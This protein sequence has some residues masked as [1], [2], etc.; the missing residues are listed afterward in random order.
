MSI[1]SKLAGKIANSVSQDSVKADFKEPSTPEMSALCREAGAEGIVMLKNKDNVLPLKKEN[2]VSVF[3]RVQ[4]DYFYVGYGSG[5]DVNAPY[6][7][8]LI[9]GMEN[10][11]DI[12]LNG[13]L[14]DI[15]KT[16]CENNPVDDGWWGHWPMCYEEMPVSTDL[17]DEMSKISDIAVVVI[18]R[19][20]GE[21]RENTLTEGSWYLTR[22]ERTMLDS[23]T[24]AFSKVVVLLDCGSIMDMSWVEEYGDSI[25]AVLYVWQG[26]MESGNSIADVLCGKVSPS[27][28]LTDTIAKKYEYYPSSKDFGNKAFNNYREDI[29]VDYRFFETFAK[30]A[31][32]YPF[33]YGLSYTD[34][35]IKTSRTVLREGALSLTVNVKNIGEHEGKEVVQVYVEP[36]QGMLGKE[37]RRLV[38]FGKTKTLAPGEDETLHL[39]FTEYECASFDD[40]GITEHRN[41]YVLEN[42]TYN[43]YVGS[44]VRDC[45]FARSIVVGKTKV[46]A[47]HVEICSPAE[48]FERLVARS[49]NGKL[50][51]R[52]LPVPVKTVDLKKRILDNMPA[53]L[54]YIGESGIMFDDVKSGKNTLEEFVAQLSFDELEAISRGDYT[55]NSKYGAAGNAGAFA[56]ITDSLQDKGIPAV[57][58]TDGPSGIRLSAG[59]SLMPNGVCLA[60]SFN[61]PLVKQLYKEIGKEMKSR[62]SDVLLAPGMNIHRNPL[63][64]RNFEYYSADPFVSGLTASAVIEGIQ[65]EGVSACPKHF[66]CNHQEVNRTHNDSRVSQRALRE[67]YLKGFE[68]AVKNASPKNIMTSYNKINGVWSH[69]NYDLCQIVLRKEWKYKGNVMTD[70]W[71][72][73]SKSPEFP[74]VSDQGYRIRAGVNVLMPGGDRMTNRKPDGTAKKSMRGKYGLTIGEMQRN[75]VEILA[76]LL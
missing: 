64:G 27:G 35:E 41:C 53:P 11:E 36:P 17:A 10:C 58:T 23:V 70:W 69:Y 26:G 49:E 52:T 28:K 5:G 63:C 76:S 33:G 45:E 40:S 48:P 34:F 74:N 47:S 57:I 6:K 71:M 75:A 32:L 56:G 39:S 30:D 13:K 68:I 72:R 66:A 15:Y 61:M 42:G 16:W 8:S 24:K 31:V 2:V 9:E 3:G 62:G 50:V 20:A 37:A 1:F 65:S 19:A 51:P 43:V 18:G 55:M 54:N 25:C 73:S 67:I 29:Y 21:D 12:T 22:T 38:A 44:S 46:L 60:S 59:C 14:V 7:I 4:L